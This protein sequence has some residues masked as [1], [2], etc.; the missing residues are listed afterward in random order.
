MFKIKKCL[1]CNEEVE[2]VFSWKDIWV[3]SDNEKICSDCRGKLA[4]LS[5]ERC[6]MC[7]RELEE[8]YQQDGLCLDCVRWEND[9]E[10]RGFLSANISLFHYNDFLKET[11]AKF[12]YRGDYALAE[13]FAS[14]VAEKIE[15]MSH[16]IIVPIPLSNERMAERGFNQAKALAETAGLKTY[17]ALLRTH[18]EKQSKKSREERI[19]LAQVFKVTGP[20]TIKGKKILLIDDIYTTGS[21]LRHAAKILKQSGAEEIYSLTLAR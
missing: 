17:D 6:K 12:K 1:I 15:H 10:W 14:F 2:S 20:D 5:G 7:S 18:T 21:T 4:F 9:S 16:D 3:S 19:R 13:A 8:K 11:I